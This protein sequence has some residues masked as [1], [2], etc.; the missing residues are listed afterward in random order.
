MGPTNCRETSVTNDQYSLRN[1]TEE[2]GLVYTAVE[3]WNH[4]QL[5]VVSFSQWPCF[6][7]NQE[8]IPRTEK[9]INLI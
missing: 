3:A 8:K 2:R 5:H 7:M 9:L 1:I 4:V 6:Q